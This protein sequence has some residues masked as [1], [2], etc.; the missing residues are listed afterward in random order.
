MKKEV[1]G[2]VKYVVGIIIF[3][4]KFEYGKK[5]DMSCVSLLYVF[6]KEEVCLKIDDPISYLHQKEQV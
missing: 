1:V 6:L 2:Y 4:V 5:K 3:L